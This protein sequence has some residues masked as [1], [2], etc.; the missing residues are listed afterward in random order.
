MFKSCT[1]F[2][3]QALCKVQIEIRKKFSTRKKKKKKFK[4]QFEKIKK[5]KFECPPCANQILI[6]LFLKKTIICCFCKQV[7]SS[8]ETFGSYPFTTF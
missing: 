2:E 1:W 3:T 5:F 4:G 7:Q 8:N 6:I